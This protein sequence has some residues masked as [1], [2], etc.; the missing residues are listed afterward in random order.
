MKLILCVLAA[1]GGCSVF[2][3]FEQ[4]R[5]G[6]GVLDANELCDDGNANDGDG[7]ESDCKL[8][9]CGDGLVEPG[10]VCYATP[11]EVDLELAGGE[12]SVQVLIG[13]VDG[14]DRLD[15]ATA[16]TASIS[17]LLGRGERFDP[18][19]RVARDTAVGAGAALADLN[20]DGLGDF[21]AAEPSLQALVVI[22]QSGAGPLADR[23]TQRQVI[24]G[25]NQPLGVTAADL[26]RDG[27]IDIAAANRD[28][29]VEAYLNNGA[30]GFETATFGITAGNALLA[31]LVEAADLDGD[32][33]P[34]LVVTNRETRAIT[35]LRNDAAGAFT[36]AAGFTLPNPAMAKAG[37]L[38]G[39]GRLDVVTANVRDNTLAAPSVSVLLGAGDGALGAA[40][41]TPI[42][43]VLGNN[44]AAALALAD[45]DADGDLDVAIVGQDDSAVNVL[46]NDGA[47]GY[48]TQDA[49]ALPANSIGI[50]AGDLN[51]D[52][53][54]DLVTVTLT[55]LLFIYLSRP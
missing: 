29:E 10:V 34:E 15:I 39:D 1:A 18:P 40:K 52:G 4:P 26:D 36:E 8:P 55:G 7:C 14:D 13:D 46:K 47:S 35:T 53:V 24:A 31:R 43:G 28:P 32:G 25:L 6:D 19:E 33:A 20:G 41:T 50:A 45:V 21:A 2:L 44:L 38:N 11:L 37:D 12:S 17:V 30:A 49:I 42:E 54:D 51:E 9:N 48:D 22:L 23:F 5:C 3:G 16:N 27:D